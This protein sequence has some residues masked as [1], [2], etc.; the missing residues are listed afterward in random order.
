MP[1]VHPQEYAKKCSLAQRYNVGKHTFTGGYCPNDKPVE[2]G[3][4]CL[5][6]VNSNVSPKLNGYVIPSAMTHWFF[7]PLPWSDKGTQPAEG[8]GFWKQLWPMDHTGEWPPP[9]PRRKAAKA[10]AKAEKRNN[11]GAGG[12]SNHK[13]KSIYCL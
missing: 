10:A 9:C 6:C 5:R 8:P 11:Q 1:M 7:P 3:F 12:D 13:G 2:P 4:V